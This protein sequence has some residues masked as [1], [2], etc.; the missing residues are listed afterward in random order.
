M[1]Q[2]GKDYFQFLSELIR[3][4]VKA[5]NVLTNTI[6]N[7][8]LRQLEN[9]IEYIN[10]ITKLVDEKKLYIFN[11]LDKEF[12]TPIEREDIIR[13]AFEINN[14]T[15]SIKYILERIYVFNISYIKKEVEE[16]AVFIFNYINELRKLVEELKNYKKSKKIYMLIRKINELR[17]EADRY[18]KLAMRKLFSYSKDPLKLILWKDIYDLLYKCCNNIIFV[19]HLV[20]NII[21]KNS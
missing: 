6:E 4:S 8:E 14:I 1:S 15:Y 18:Y 7:F 3:Y 17:M 19:T 11:K 16:F 5:A 21:L 13:L 20:E 9:N 12:I 10:T 2:K